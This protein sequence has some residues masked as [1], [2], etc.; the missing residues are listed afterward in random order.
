MTKLR[1]SPPLTRWNQSF[2]HCLLSVGTTLLSVA[3]LEVETSGRN[4]FLFVSPRQLCWR[5]TS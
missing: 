5:W 3:S 1:T 2:R 4:G